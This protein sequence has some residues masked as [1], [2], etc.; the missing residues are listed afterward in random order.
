VQ[1][2]SVAV[3]SLAPDTTYH[4]HLVA[5][6]G[7]GTTN[8]PDA[9]FR[10]ASPP[11][12]V[13]SAPSASSVTAAGATVTAKVNANGQPTKYYVDYGTTTAYGNQTTPTSAPGGTSAQPVTATLSGLTE[14]TTYH[15]RLV[16]SSPSGTTAGA[17]A[18]FVTATPPTLAPGTR[19]DAALPTT[20]GD[21]AAEAPADDPADVPDAPATPRIGR[22]VVV[23]VERGTV[24]V[25]RPGARFPVPLTADRPVPVGSVVDTSRG[26]LT[27]TTALP[28][29]RS[30]QVQLWGGRVRISQT[31]S[32]G[33]MTDLTTVDRPVCATR[34]GAAKRRKPALVWAKDHNGRFRSHGRNSVATVRGTIWL[35]EETCAGT[36]T[37]VA[38]GKVAVRDLHTHRTV[39]V[40]AGHGYLAKRR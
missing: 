6:N 32:G 11:P 13:L 33:G 17:D 4:F 9:T 5:T 27:L 12:P 22:T 8:G 39:L 18:T 19:Q 35:T 15:Y 26:T 37:K 24:L 29:G 2:V 40:T 28:G 20:P 30:Q 23:G 10:T 3:G 14:G 7:T 34:A 36:L 25:Q 16:A 31:T 21:T 1:T 38:Q